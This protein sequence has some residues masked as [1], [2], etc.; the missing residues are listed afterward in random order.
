MAN[1]VS[2]RLKGDD[3][4]HLFAWF[5]ILA[6][7]L[8]QKKV[9]EV[10]VEDSNASSI[11]DVTVKHEKGSGM[12]DLFHQVKYHVDH[13]GSYSTAELCKQG[14]SQKSLLKKLY[15]SWKV[16]LENDPPTRPQIFLVSNWT[17]DASDKFKMCISGKDY[18]VTDDFLTKSA[19]S[20]VGKIRNLWIEEIGANF[21]DF[22][23]FVRGLRF[24]L[25]FDSSNDL[26][27]RVAE[28]MSSRGL[29]HDHIALKVVVGIVREWVKDGTRSIDRSRLESAL[30]KHD[31]YASDEN[32]R[33][34][35][36]YMHTIKKQ[37]FDIPPDH[38][39]D[40]TDL[41]EGKPNKKGHFPKNPADW[42][43]RMLPELESLEAEINESTDCRLIRA[44]GLA[45][46]S[47]WFALGHAFSEVARY[48]IEV[49]QGDALW[50]TS[51]APTF[52]F[53][54]GVTNGED[55]EALG[56]NAQVVA[57]GV[58]VTGSLDEDVRSY[59][60]ATGE[61]SRLLLLRPNREL[62]FECLR[63]GCDAMALARDFKRRAVTFVKLT[64]AK[65][66]L[67]FYY[68]PLAGACF[69]GHVSN[70]VCREIQIMEDQQPG[71]APSFCLE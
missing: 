56:G 61:V 22:R 47:A 20:D 43:G 36:V 69:I 9:V 53:S 50:R 5:H 67:L 17:W 24:Q 14:P 64:G 62:G 3:Y 29:R 63:S 52:D 35:A 54:L 15:L 44:R 42:N 18:S 6:L 26:E 60:G 4:Q 68:G 28:R 70:A 30:Q 1:Q 7:L 46:L 12:P 13:R 37:S 49:A 25:G 31:L 32:E 59:L 40:W 58:S 48:T 41:F 19:N 51:D 45:R 33:S 2:A 66:L 16:L 27:E 39:L 21:H 23:E 10:V 65:K 71:Y 38:L 57:I 34:V 55:G 11:D 8:P